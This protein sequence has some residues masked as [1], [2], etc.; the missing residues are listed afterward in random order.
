MLFDPLQSSCENNGGDSLAE[1][2]EMV[3][4]L[5]KELYNG[6]S[7]VWIQLLYFTSELI[8][9]SLFVLSGEK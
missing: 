5:G 7:Q 6:R 3:R 8:M 2:R 4:I 9:Q 1:V